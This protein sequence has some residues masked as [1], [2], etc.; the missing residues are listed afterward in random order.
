MPYFKLGSNQPSIT[1]KST[2]KSVVIISCY[3][4]KTVGESKRPGVVTRQ[5]GTIEWIVEE[6]PCKIFE[7]LSRLWD[8]RRIVLT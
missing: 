8:Y 5:E 4:L 1:I 3:G 6:E 7:S 2:V